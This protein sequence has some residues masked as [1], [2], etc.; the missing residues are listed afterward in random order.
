[1]NRFRVIVASAALCLVL[2]SQGPRARAA[3]A[4]SNAVT[5]GEFI[6]DP[7]TLINLGFEWM[8]QG[9]DNRNAAVA[10]S[11]RKKGESQWR[12]GMPLLRLQNEEIFQGDRLDVVAPNMFAGSILD[13]EPDT[14]YEARFVLSDPDGVQGV[15]QR[16]VSVRKRPEPQPYTGGRTFH[17]YPPGYK[18]AKTEPAFEG[19]MCAYNFWCAGTDWA[20]SGR[21]RVV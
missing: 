19:L 1:M 18:G 21:P 9:D 2:V 4:K 17:V 7:P 13:L 5:S 10:V 3:D 11:Y 16:T 14:E 8:I 12:Q 15:A 20:T 6:I